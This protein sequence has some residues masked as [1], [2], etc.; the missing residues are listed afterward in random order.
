MSNGPL[1]GFRIID[2]TAV[3]AGPLA[4]RLLADLGADV[5]RIEQVSKDGGPPRGIDAGRPA[6]SGSLHSWDQEPGFR[7]FNRGK[8]SLPLDLQHPDGRRVLRRLVERSSG[9]V[10]NFSARVLPNAGL[11]PHRLAELNPRLTCLTITGYGRFG[12]HSERVAYGPML[13]CESGL[14][15]LGGYPDYPTVTKNVFADVATAVFATSAFITALYEVQQTGQGL[16]VDVSMLEVLGTLLGSEY[17]ASR[18]GYFPQPRRRLTNAIDSYE[19]NG[20]VLSS[21]R[22]WVAVSIPMERHWRSLG[23]LP[24]FSRLLTDERFSTSE[25]RKQNAPSLALEMSIIC[26]QLSADEL[27]E[28]LRCASI[29]AETVA[30]ASDILPPSDVVGDDFWIESQLDGAI[31]AVLDVGSAYSLDGRRLASDVDAPLFGEHTRGILA[32]V[33]GYSRDEVDALVSGGVTQ[34]AS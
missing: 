19:Y 14:S 10:T 15:A 29:P 9:L 8:R 32:D 18:A 12:M 21:D 7:T 13:E 5:I 11:P 4:A 26:A 33:C 2:W 17:L 20:C 28:T 30:Y 6:I 16:F 1:S 27:T 25:G 23:E 22:R 31:R 34:A 24:H 3:V